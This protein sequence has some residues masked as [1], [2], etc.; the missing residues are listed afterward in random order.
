MRTLTLSVVLLVAISSPALA[1]RYKPIHK[2]KITPYHRAKDCL[3][4]PQSEAVNYRATCAT[5]RN[6]TMRCYIPAGNTTP[7]LDCCCEYD[8]Q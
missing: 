8:S 6:S 4:I 2:L 7:T 3:H 1:E 5:F